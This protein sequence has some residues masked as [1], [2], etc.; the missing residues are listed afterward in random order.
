MKI[1]ML[2]MNVALEEIKQ[3]EEVSPGGIIRPSTAATGDLRLGKVISAGPGEVQFGTFVENKVKEGQKVLFD[4][5][6]SKEFKKTLVL[7]AR[8]ILGVVE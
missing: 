5:R 7:G 3:E 2:G 6:L 8:D 1:E 4:K